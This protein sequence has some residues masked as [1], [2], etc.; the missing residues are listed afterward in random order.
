M[1]GV[2][3]ASTVACPA[4]A[5]VGTAGDTV[6]RQASGM[7]ALARMSVSRLTTTMRS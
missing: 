5:A 2:P 6:C 3:D 1:D 4:R 7:S